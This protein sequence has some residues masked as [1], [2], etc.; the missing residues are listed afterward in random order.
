VISALATR[1]L[2]LP[3]LPWPL[4][5]GIATLLCFAA[6]GAG[7]WLRGPPFLFFFP[8]V[9]IVAILFDHGTSIFAALLLSAM[10]VG[11]MLPANWP[12]PDPHNL[13]ALAIFL[14]TGIVMG[15]VVEALRHAANRLS[16]TNR[17]LLTA[18]AERDI[19]MRMFD[20]LLE[21][22]DDPIYVKGKD[23][24]FVHLNQAA[25]ALLGATIQLAIGKRDRDFLPP[26][27]ADT[28]EAND[29][30]V[31]AGSDVIVIEEAIPTPQGNTR[32]FLSS[33]FAWTDMDGSV[34]GLMGISRDITDRKSAEDRLRAA[35]A[36]KELLLH[37]I[38][39]RVKNHLQT[40]VGLMSVAANRI[41]SVDQAREIIDVTAARLAVLGGVYNR[42][43]LGS[44]AS[45]VDARAFLSELCGDLL[46]GLVGSAPVTIES[47]ADATPIEANRAVTVGLFVNELVQNALKHA[48]PGGRPGRIRIN[49]TR[50]DRTFRLEVG[51]D[52]IGFEPGAGRQTASGQ[53]LIKAMAQQL[54]GTLAVDGGPGRGAQFVLEFP[55]TD[56]CAETQL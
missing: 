29:R 2:L 49:L 30:R 21:G 5:Y 41:D 9:L 22:T 20:A 28:V 47:H 7:L 13:L 42:L 54:G 3:R 26:D 18:V 1:L 45:V 38:N 43:Q 33:K 35:D 56:A 32:H 34:L 12:H 25:A 52:G 55:V 50:S 36:Q 15:S 24:R 27:V 4:R 6:L 11:R 17:A 40:I 14:V 53:R 10:A 37:D 31:M 39:H 23:H 8:T 48:F 51:D 44:S 46:T 19:T 16:D